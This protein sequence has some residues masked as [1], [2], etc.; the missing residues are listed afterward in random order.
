M[1]SLQG[2]MLLTNGQLV[3]GCGHPPVT[4]AE[5]LIED[6]RIGYAGPR[7]PNREL[8]AEALVLDARGG[9][10]LPGLVEAHFHPTYFNVAALEDL[11]T[12]YPVE[13]VSL[14]ASVNA[15]LALESG[16]TAARSGGSLFNI[17]VWL[18]KAI[19]NDLVP[20][21]RLAA[22]GREICGIG[23]LMDWNPDFRKI[24]MEGL[25]LLVNGPDEARAAVRKLVKD[26]I[27]WVKTYPTGDAAAP[28]T[29]DHH[30]LC[31][32]FEEMHAVVETAH[33]HGLKVTGHCRATAGIKN[34]LRAGYDTIEHGT[35]M[36]DEALDLLLERDVPVIP[37]LYFEK[38]SVER[39]PAIG[40]PQGV[41]DGHQETLDGGVESARRIFEA[42]GRLGLGG[43]Y[44]FAW[45]PHG[46]YANELEF[47]VTDVGFPPVDVIKCACKTGAEILGREKE[48]GTLEVGK[49][50]D[51]VVVDGDVLDNIAILQDRSRFLAI[52]QA[53]VI[54]AG[55]LQ[56]QHLPR[57]SE[58][59]LES[60]KPVCR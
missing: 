48:L 34:A 36:D 57:W 19:E 41:I 17:D 16:Y 24:G 8:P 14:L 32:T 40:M 38:A 35:F 31:M 52:M 43:D 33:N 39:G 1:K 53:G 46:D 44:G 12:K 9:T 27:E 49:L 30:T 13:Y 28:D 60:E 21:P 37:A 29:N 55:S 18:K 15:K 26:G 23:G 51:V 2:T 11:D 22:S 10:I 4:D 5:L 45:N 25:V 54:N 7:Q 6:G 20:G 59:A 42:G 50:A 3:D 58:H 47:F 56:H